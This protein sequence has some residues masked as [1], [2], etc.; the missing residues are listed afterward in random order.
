MSKINIGPVIPS[1]PITPNQVINPFTKWF[2]ITQDSIRI[3]SDDGQPL[4]GELEEF[5]FRN[6]YDKKTEKKFMGKAFKIDFE[7]YYIIDNFTLYFSNKEIFKPV[8]LEKN[9]FN[10]INYYDENIKYRKND[11]FITS[12]NNW[13]IM[14]EH[15]NL[16]KL[17]EEEIETFE[18]IIKLKGI[19]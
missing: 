2:D 12:K 5:K 7:Y 3:I 1:T 13:I 8:K 9:K 11:Y 15:V 10:F 16:I 14:N 4:I 6:C 17:K 19:K 18:K